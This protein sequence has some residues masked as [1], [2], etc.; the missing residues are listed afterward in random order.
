MKTQDQDRLIAIKTE[1]VL[2]L[3][4]LVAELKK[5][6]DLLTSVNQSKDLYIAALEASLAN[7]KAKNQRLKTVA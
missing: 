7:E 6:L 4:S 1:Q 2:T 3:Q 5:Q